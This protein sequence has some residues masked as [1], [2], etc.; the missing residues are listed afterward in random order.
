[1]TL[2]EDSQHSPRA[3]RLV[4]A[5]LFWTSAGLLL[6]ASSCSTEPPPAAPGEPLTWQQQ[7]YQNQQQ[8]S[9]NHDQAKTDHPL[10]RPCRPNGNCF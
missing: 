1:M 10:T 7:F 9:I 5:A 6:S 8:A 2:H 4:A 3:L